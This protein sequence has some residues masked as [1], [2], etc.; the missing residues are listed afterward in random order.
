MDAILWRVV[1]R[2]IVCDG[3]LSSS[4]CVA[5]CRSG[6]AEETRHVL[7]V[8]GVI[9]GADDPT[10]PGCAFFVFEKYDVASKP[11]VVGSG[12]ELSRSGVLQTTKTSDAVPC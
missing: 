10:R 5:R 2:N 8:K 3:A 6:T 7:V 1:D 9:E 11:V 4:G 12:L